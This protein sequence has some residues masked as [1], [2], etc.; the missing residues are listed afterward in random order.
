[1]SGLTVLGE[2]MAEADI[3]CGFGYFV[4]RPVADI[5][6]DARYRGGQSFI[7]EVR[8]LNSPALPLADQNVT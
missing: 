6:S 8:R 1:M 4:F 7:L 3:R 5:G 2:G